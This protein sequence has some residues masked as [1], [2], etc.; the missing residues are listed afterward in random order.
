MP[1]RTSS[2]PPAVPANNDA[3]VDS[4]LCQHGGTAGATFFGFNSKK[5]KYLA[6][7]ET[8][9]P[10][11]REFVLAYDQ[12]QCGFIKF[13]GPGR[14]PDRKM[15]PMFGGFIPPNVE[16]LPD[17]DQSTWDRNDRG[18][19]RDPWQYQVM[20]PLY[21]P[22]DNAAFIFSTSSKTGLNAVAKLVFVARKMQRTTPDDYPLVKLEVSN[23]QHR[24]PYVGK[25]EIP[26]FKAI[27]AVKKD[28]RALKDVPYDQD[29]SDCVPF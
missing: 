18:E 16:D 3:G 25:V 23:F 15:G 29:L 8:E 6:R 11:G 20:L 4:F 5:G 9:I 22:D 24:D 2:P 17:R 12:I 28:G 27:G 13:N 7:D 14:M 19:L 1:A 21:S 26:V 10:S